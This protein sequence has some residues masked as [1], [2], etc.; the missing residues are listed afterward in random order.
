VAAQREL[1]AGGAEALQRGAELGRGAAVGDRHARAAG[2]RDARRGHAAAGEADHEH[3]PA[4]EA[5]GVGH[6]AFTSA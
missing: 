3:A 5:E 6:L 2:E 1:D 4:G